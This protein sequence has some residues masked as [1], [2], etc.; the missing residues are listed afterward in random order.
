MNFEVLSNP[1]SLAKLVT[2]YRE[3]K[4]LTKA[5]FAEK[6]NMAP[7]LVSKIESGEGGISLSTFASIFNIMG[8]NLGAEINHS[9]VKLVANYIAGL[10][11]EKIEAVEELNDL[12]NLKLQ[13]LLYYVHLYFVS[14]TGKGIFPNKFQAWGYGPVH[15]DLYS[16]FK[17]QTKITP[18]P[19]YEKAK[20]E[21]TQ[22]EQAGIKFVVLKLGLINKSAFGLVEQTHTENNNKNPWKDV[23]I[24]NCNIPI[25]D[26]VISK[27]ART[28]I[29]KLKL[30]EN[31]PV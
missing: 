24:P 27:Y 9:K 20:E 14:E 22:F 2:E 10:Y 17:S 8:E 15:P 19:L 30:T 18:G 11:W 29:N 5:E 1:T 31:M 25:N 21:L 16:E 12:S 4:G 23:F 26:E 7:S 13:K 6:A 28:I 3:S